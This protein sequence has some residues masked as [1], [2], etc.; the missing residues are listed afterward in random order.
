MY[1]SHKRIS[2]IMAML[3]LVI[4][5]NKNI[6]M[7]KGNNSIGSVIY[8]EVNV[9]VING[10]K[11]TQNN[12]L[13]S[14]SSYTKM[15]INM[16]CNSVY[17]DGTNL[18]QNN[19]EVLSSTNTFEL[20]KG[21]TCQISLKEITIGGA[22]F[23][24]VNSNMLSLTISPTITALNT[25]AL[26]YVDSNM[27]QYYLAANADGT[28]I[29]IQY[30]TLQADAENIPINIIQANPVTVAVSG[31]SVPVLSNLNL[32]GLASLNGSNPTLTFYG[33][34]NGFILPQP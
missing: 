25:T 33:S 10:T 2:I 4:G 12:K 27:N 13:T 26:A 15:Q 6:E 17:P 11:S 34:A 30:A 9:A 16:Q 24:S 29:N 28:Q 7:I 3:L 19:I 18:T 21:K 5:C 8:K 20:V 31:V 23:N 14:D 32:F 22:T 1:Y